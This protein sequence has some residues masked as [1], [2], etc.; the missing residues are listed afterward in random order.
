MF[1]KIIY[2]LVILIVIFGSLIMPRLKNK[3][4]F[5]KT[6]KY[7]YENLKQDIKINLYPIC[8][9]LVLTPERKAAP[10]GEHGF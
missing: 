4:T 6:L 2:L 3:S 1:F 10:F 7:L 5:L 9:D 8:Q